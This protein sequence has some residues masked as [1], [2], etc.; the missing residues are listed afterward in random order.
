M[1]MDKSIAVIIPCYN[2]G[3]TIERVVKQFSQILPSATIYVFDNNSEDDSA[4]R[5]IN[6]GA[7]V[8]NEIQQGKGYVIRRAFAD[9]EADIYILV[10]GDG[11]YE[12]ASAQQMTQVLIDHRLDMVVGARQSEA[13]EA[14]RRGHR[15]GNY[16]FNFVVAMLFGSCF[17]DMLS[18]YRIFS[19]RFVKSFPALAVGFDIETEMT[20]HAL[21]LRLPVAEIKTPYHARPLG[22]ESKLSTYCDGLKILWRILILMKETKPFHLF[23]ILF[24]FSMMG[25]LL[26]AIPIINTFIETGLIPRLSSAIIAVG[27]ILIGLLSLFSGIILDSLSK[28]RL[29]M[30][31][32][33][34]LTFK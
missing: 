2:E 20:I 18:G 14:F 22:S 17:N 13:R 24:A 12:A 34:Y 10:D 31:R 19:R 4:I 26:L 33:S 32:L 23:A 27:L 29:E 16:L 11:T 8:Y 5:A 15:I 1:Y 9:I 25:A 21:H 30:K 28:A 7:L 6:A 3:S